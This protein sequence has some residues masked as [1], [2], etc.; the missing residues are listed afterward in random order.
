MTSSRNNPDLA[1]P[2]RPAA[3]EHAP[4][5]SGL[6]ATADG[7]FV[8]VRTRTGGVVAKLAYP[9][10]EKLA[11]AMVRQALAGQD[12]VVVYGQLELIR[13]PAWDAHR[14]ALELAAATGEAGEFDGGPA[15]PP[16][17]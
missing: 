7:P 10:A 13:V 1:L 5:V 12:V 3:A 8:R 9:E 4:P 6:T 11:S 14:F 2:V 17:A 16:A 15:P